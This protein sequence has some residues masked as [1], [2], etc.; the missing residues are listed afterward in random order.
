MG[1][2]HG[3]QN[4]PPDFCVHSI[5]LFCICVQVWMWARVLTCHSELCR[6]QRTSF[7]DWSP[8]LPP[9][10]SRESIVLTLT[11]NTSTPLSHLTSCLVL[12]QR[13]LTLHLI[14]GG[15]SPS[16]RNGP[17][18]DVTREALDPKRSS[19]TEELRSQNLRTN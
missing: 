19:S 12:T 15:C 16:I 4:F 11:A 14:L 13:C 1:L 5:Y 3:Q 17:H 18:P 7:R 9:R 10:G 8:P 6:G 2:I